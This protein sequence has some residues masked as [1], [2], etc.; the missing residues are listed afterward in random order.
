MTEGLNRTQA[1]ILTF[2]I[3]FLLTFLTFLSGWSKYESHQNVQRF[4]ELPKEYV[5]LERYSCDQNRLYESL[6]DMNRKLDRLIEQ[7]HD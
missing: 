4:H 6:R 3:I 1:K 5:R 2:L 7:R